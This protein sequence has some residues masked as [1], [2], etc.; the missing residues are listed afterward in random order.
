M[1]R[2]RVLVTGVGLTLLLVLGAAACGG[3]VEPA[4]QPAVTDEVAASETTPSGVEEEE[5]AAE[6]PVLSAPSEPAPATV[7]GRTGDEELAPEVKGIESWI[8]SEPF[9]LGSQRGKVVLVDF[10]TYTCINCIRTFPYLKDWHEKYADQGL[11]IVGVHT[12]EFEFEKKRENVI[13][14]AMK[15]GLN[16]PIAQ[17]N[18][19]E[20]W[21]A[22]S[23]QYWP[24]KYLIDKDGYIRYT[25]FGEGAYVETEEKIRELLEEA[26]AGVSDIALNLE[27][28]R[29]IDARAF[30]RDPFTMITRELYAGF[31]RNYRALAAGSAPPYVLHE[32]F[33]QQQNA[34]ILYEDPGEHLNQF[35]YLQ[36]LWQNG[37]ESLRHARVTDNYEDYM[38]IKFYATSVNVVMS[39]AT[40]ESY[41]VRITM[42]GEPLDPSEAGAD[43]Q[44]DEDGNSYLLVGASEMYRLVDIPEYSGHELRLSSNSDD[45]SVFAFTFGAFRN[46]PES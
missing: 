12:P 40:G 46:Q 32:E 2:P 15:H 24:A 1:A 13:D 28:E 22:Y 23:N 39:L 37:A 11:V 7:S 21:N 14:A 5:S 17:D 9:T 16:Y 34:D 36:G 26:Q 27:P 19:F 33:Y 4:G 25:H 10:W 45:F 42:D 29:E 30:T 18:D 41:E 31:R 20:T 3:D 38:A 8:N 35:I 43:I 6:T 44:F